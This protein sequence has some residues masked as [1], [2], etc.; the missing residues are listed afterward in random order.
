[1]N[2]TTEALKRVEVWVE[3]L[4]GLHPEVSQEQGEILDAIRNALAEQ[5]KQEPIGWTHAANLVDDG[6]GHIFSVHSSEPAYDDWVPVYAAPISVEASV[7]AERE[8]CAKLID[9]KYCIEDE[10][11]AAIR[12]RGEHV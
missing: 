9:E 12:A 2:K 5:E 6:Y 10:I 7:L 1:M 3:S 8:A 4:T 11:A